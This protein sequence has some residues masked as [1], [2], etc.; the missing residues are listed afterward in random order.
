MQYRT[1]M[2]YNL[3]GGL[4]WTFGVT[5]GG[6][7]LGK[8]IPADKIDKYLLPIILPI[9]VVLIA[10]SVVHLYQEHQSAKKSANR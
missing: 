5:I 7:F 2:F 8:I 6:F 4:V 10:P 9:I 1:F 3:I